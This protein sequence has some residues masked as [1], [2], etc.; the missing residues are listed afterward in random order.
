[1]TLSQAKFEI[2]FLEKRL[3]HLQSL[4]SSSS[5]SLPPSLPLPLLALELARKSFQLSQTHIQAKN[6]A[7]AE[8]FL[9]KA[10]KYTDPTRYSF[11]SPEWQVLRVRILAFLG[12]TLWKLGK[13]EEAGVLFG[14]LDRHLKVEKMLKSQGGEELV[15]SLE[16]VWVGMGREAFRRRE[17]EKVNEVA[18]KAEEVIRKM[19]GGGGE[20]GGVEGRV[21]KFY[22]VYFKCLLYDSL[23]KG[24]VSL[25]VSRSEVKSCAL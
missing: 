9:L 25:R 21:K 11:E 4:P 15:E 19:R 2:S 20:G 22:R 24:I 17:V 3:L 5:S 13:W 23:T 18:K 12:K 1:M 8:T 7:K 16:V 10:R 6:Y 14:K